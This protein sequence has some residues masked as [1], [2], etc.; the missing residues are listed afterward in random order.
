MFY[1][2]VGPGIS[3]VYENW[4]KVEDL[5]KLFPYCKYRK[6]KTEEECWEFVYRNKYGKNELSL[7]KYG[8]T[9]ENVFVRMSYIVRS[10]TMY[11]SYNTKHIGNIRLDPIPGALIEYTA[12]C[13]MV[14]MKSEILLDNSTILSHLQVINR[15]IEILGDLIDVDI[16]VPDHSIYYALTAYTGKDEYL[17]LMK[18]R[19]KNRLAGVSF[20]LYVK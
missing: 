5:S 15:G 1:A 9:F 3:G 7:T 2:I 13:I 16:V 12:H 6:F 10:D 11:F 19:L 14:K 20:S 4:S 8:N 17:K 18:D